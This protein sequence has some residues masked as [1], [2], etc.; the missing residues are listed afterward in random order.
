L[1]GHLAEEL[2]QPLGDAIYHDVSR[3]VDYQ[4][5]EKDASN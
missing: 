3:A 5:P 2:R 4:A 1:L